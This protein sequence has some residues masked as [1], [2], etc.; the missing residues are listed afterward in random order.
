[1]TADV[2]FIESLV[3]DDVI[4]IWYFDRQDAIQ[5]S[6][7]NF[8]HDLPRFL[9]FLLIMQRMQYAQWGHNPLFDPEPASSVT[10]KVP[11]EKL[12]TVD[13]EFDFTS[14][15][16]TTHY[17]LR[18][19]ATNVFPVKSVRLSREARQRPSRNKTDELVA[20]IYWPEQSRQSEAEILEE[21]HKIAA[22]NPEVKDH[23][24]DV[25]WSRKFEGT[26]TAK[27]RE[28]LGIDDAQVGSRVLYIIVFR[29]LRPIT[30]LSGDRFL[31]AWWQAVRCKYP[32]F[33]T[34]L[35]SIDHDNRPS[36][37]LGKGHSPS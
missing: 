26:S 32:L 6:G 24:P 3:A 13:L 35:L 10:V 36:Y 33:L 29:K 11:D 17:G 34:S 22:E 37:P 1:M 28:A 15:E 4:Y 2:P 7:F 19:R 27:I 8:I 18:G 12:G 14:S 31:R 16:R 21:V 30:Q 23:V 20:K 9:V 25:I 5:C